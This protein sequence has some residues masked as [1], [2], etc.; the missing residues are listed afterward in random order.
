[1]S[2]KHYQIPWLFVQNIPSPLFTHHSCPSA[3]HHTADTPHDQ[4]HS[5]GMSTHQTRTKKYRL[6]ENKYENNKKKLYFKFYT[7]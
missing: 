4:T 3:R 2:L 7:I 5:S 6:S 1:M